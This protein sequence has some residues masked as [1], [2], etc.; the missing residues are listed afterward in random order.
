MANELDLERAELRVKERC[1]VEVVCELERGLV[2][3]AVFLNL[4]DGGG[5]KA[6]L[7]DGISPWNASGRGSGRP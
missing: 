2:L 7:N 6:N 3:L 1:S 5:V 4:L